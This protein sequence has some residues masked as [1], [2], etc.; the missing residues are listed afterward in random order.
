MDTQDM[1]FLFSMPQ[2]GITLNGA[3][4]GDNSGA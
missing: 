3:D 1:V 4:A 2:P